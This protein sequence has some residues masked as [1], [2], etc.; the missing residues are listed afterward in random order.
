MGSIESRIHEAL[1]KKLANIGYSLVSV[2]YARENKENY[3]HLTIDKDDDMSLDDIVMVSD[4]ISPILD[5]EDIIKDKYILDISSLGAEKPIALNKIDKY[6]GK[7]LNIHLSHPYKGMN[8]I[9][10][11]L[12]KVDETNVEMEYKEKTRTIKV[13]LERKYIDR[14]NLAIKF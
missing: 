3:L 14:I 11:T 9:L 1:D 2:K 4:L 6:I 5:I 12:I 10:A 13:V 8:N 7:Y